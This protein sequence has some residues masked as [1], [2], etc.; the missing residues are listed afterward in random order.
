MIDMDDLD[1]GLV[2]ECI[3]IAIIINLIGFG[4]AALI[5]Y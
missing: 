1:M 5:C 2:Y 3:G 4:V